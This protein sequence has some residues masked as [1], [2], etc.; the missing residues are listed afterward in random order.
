[1]IKNNKWKLL[2]S[3]LIILLPIAVGLILW[4]QLPAQ[5]PIHWGVDG[6]ADGWAGRLTAV[7]ALPIINLI[8]H[9]AT[10]LA[11]SF[12]KKGLGKN[13]KMFSILLWICPA[14]SLATNAFVYAFAL[15]KEF[16][17][18][19]I[20][21]L[22]LGVLFVAVGNY[23]PKCTR[24]Y[25][26]GIKIK[27]TL[28]NDENWNATHRFGGKVWVGAGLVVIASVFLP[29]TLIPWVMVPALLTAAILPIVYSY[30]YHKKQLAA[31][32]AEITPIPQSKSTKIIVI[33]SL[34]FTALLLVFCAVLTFTGDVNV[35][36]QDDSFTVGSAYWQDLT[37]DY[38]AIVAIEYREKD[39]PGSR[40]SGFGTPRLL[41]G[42]FRNNEFGNYTRYSYTEC[43]SC[44]VITLEG[45]T[46]VI[47]G[48]DPTSTKTIYDTIQAK[49]G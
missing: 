3:S 20:V 9:W 47:S 10:I 38:D 7:L 26:T 37:V 36:Y 32:T 11:M 4:D 24:N 5:M 43:T 25:T 44:V 19:I 28:Q 49:I 45:K 14:I 8:I 46:L 33:A 18:F 23:L 31:G 40:V 41:M 17:P 30:R 12:D 27:W 16:Q 39:D 35:T 34:I 2:I 13:P 21:P 1:M 42:N 48:T 15:G 6:N 29:E 22:L